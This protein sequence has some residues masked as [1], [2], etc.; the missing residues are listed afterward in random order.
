[1][2]IFQVQ[3]HISLY[4]WPLH[5]IIPTILDDSVLD[6]SDTFLDVSILNIPVLSI[7]TLS[8]IAWWLILSLLLDFSS[9]NQ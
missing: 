5:L 3:G 4:H 1:M 7:Y 2:Y 9:S 8:S 6:D